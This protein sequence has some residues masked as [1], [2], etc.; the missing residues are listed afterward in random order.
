MAVS[1]TV[2]GGGKWR[3]EGTISRSEFG[4]LSSRRS[5]DTNRRTFQSR[6]YGRAHTGAEC[7]IHPGLQACLGFVVVA[8]PHLELI[9][10]EGREG[11]DFLARSWQCTTLPVPQPRSLVRRVG[12]VR[13]SLG[14]RS[15]S[16][17]GCGATRKGS[18]CAAWSGKGALGR[19]SAQGG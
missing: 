4:V 14:P 18:G 17:I 12:H 7:V 13:K 3:G 15:A 5:D 2:H 10:E 8:H 16:F 1:S 11:G 9:D 19:V 6:C